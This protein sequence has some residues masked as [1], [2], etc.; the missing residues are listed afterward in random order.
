MKKQFVLFTLLLYSFSCASQKKE[1]ISKS[2]IKLEDKNTNIRNLLD[3]DGYYTSTP[4]QKN[5]GNT[6]FFEDGTWVYFHFKRDATDSEIKNNLSKSIDI[7]S[8]N[9]NRWGTNWG[10]YTIK[11]DT[12]ILNQYDKG[13]FFGNSWS[14]SESRCKIIDRQTIKNIY[15]KSL[16]KLHESYYEN[17]S[18][19]L[20]GAESHFIATDSLPSSDCWLKEEKWIWRNESDWREYMDKI[21]LKKEN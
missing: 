12:I 18:P 9:D 10:V 8:E 5:L 11:N 14:L 19:W 7:W 6:M 13:S 4:D 16:M 17:N 3:I 20:N 1:V 21:K 15:S 2:I